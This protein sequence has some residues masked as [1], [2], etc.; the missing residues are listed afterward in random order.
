MNNLK[1]SFFLL[2]TSTLILSSACNKDNGDDTILG[3][4][5]CKIT[6]KID[7]DSFSEEVIACIYDG[8]TLNVG[9]VGVDDA[10]VQVD[11]IMST[12]TY[13]LDLGSGTTVY[14]ALKLPDGTTLAAKSATV[15][16][17]KLSDNR[18]SGTFQGIFL[19]VM[20]ISQTTEYQVTDGT[21]EANF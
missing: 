15:V 1:L 13:E 6:W 3:G 5:G 16:V 18:A 8:E 12:G 9:S 4:Q 17:D 14:I 21:F 11:P 2:L 10:Q 19:D 20:D 7:G